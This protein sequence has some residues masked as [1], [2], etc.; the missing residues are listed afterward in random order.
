MQVRLVM[1][2]LLLLAG[3]ARSSVLEYASDTLQITTSAAP[4][5]GQAGAQE[6]AN[7]QASIETLK[8]GYDSY[9]VLN[10]G[11]ENDVRVVGRTPVIAN[12]HGSGTVTGY[13]NTAT[14]QG[15][16]TTKY[17]G[18]MPIVGGHH[19]QGIIIKMYHDGDPKSRNAID[20]RRVLGPDWQKTI[21]KSS[22]TTC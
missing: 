17:S 15:Q 3:C 2:A 8:D 14:I 11:Y 5:C 22:T 12:T 10:A 21:R 13:G 1:V 6:V 19:T 18:G 9:I 7:R 4:V 20:A 16:S